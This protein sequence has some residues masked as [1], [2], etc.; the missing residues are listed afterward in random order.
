M[1]RPANAADRPALLRLLASADL[2]S[3]GIPEDLAHFVVGERDGELEGAAGLELYGGHALLR[4]VVVG[5]AARGTGLGSRLV[6]RALDAARDAGIREVFLLTTTAEGWFPRFGFRAVTHADV[7][8]A[9]RE[10]VEFRGACPASAAVLALDLVETR[11][12][13]YSAT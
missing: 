12:P 5:E 7:P 9:V 6:E 3:A 1:I 2:P 13:R 11:S 10:S 8:P 4:S